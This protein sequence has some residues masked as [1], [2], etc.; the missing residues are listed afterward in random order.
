[1][2]KCEHLKAIMQAGVVGINIED[3]LMGLPALNTMSDQC[4]ILASLPRSRNSPDW[5]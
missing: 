2:N 3:Q 1:M 5:A 4:Q